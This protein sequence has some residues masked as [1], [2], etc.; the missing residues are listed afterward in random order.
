M[1]QRNQ[2]GLKKEQ[3]YIKAP[4][5]FCDDRMEFIEVLITYLFSSGL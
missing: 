2:Q 5:N 1:V 3:S 4:E